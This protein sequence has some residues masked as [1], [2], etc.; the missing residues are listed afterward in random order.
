MFDFFSSKNK[1]KTKKKKSTELAT[2]TA[3][4]AKAFATKP[5]HLGLIPR[6]HMKEG[7]NLPQSLVL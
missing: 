1:N 3:Q 5:D 7:E 2:D 4:Q 6:L